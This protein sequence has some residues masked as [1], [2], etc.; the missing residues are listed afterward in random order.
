MWIIK[1]KMGQ[2]KQYTYLLFCSATHLVVVTLIKKNL[3]PHKQQGKSKGI[4]GIAP[5]LLLQFKEH[6]N[7]KCCVTTQ[8]YPTTRPLDT[9][10][11]VALQ[12]LLGI[13][14]AK[15]L[16]DHC[17]MHFSG[18]TMRACNVEQSE[19]NK[20]KIEKTWNELYSE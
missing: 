10:K 7:V 8:P 20:K 9:S 3:P 2:L 6:T 13:S 11:L 19:T 12:A 14:H 15:L 5:T 4:L 1:E 16:I 17:P 18:V